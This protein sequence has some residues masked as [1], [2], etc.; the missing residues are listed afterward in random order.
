MENTTA[1]PNESSKI[2][3]IRWEYQTRGSSDWQLIDGYTLLFRLLPAGR[4][5]AYRMA[6]QQISIEVSQ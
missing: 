4:V 2:S 5:S 3:G 1:M 6:T